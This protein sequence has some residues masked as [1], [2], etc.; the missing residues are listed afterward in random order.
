MASSPPAEAP[1]PTIVNVMWGLICKIPNEYMRGSL[2]TERGLVPPGRVAFAGPAL[3]LFSL[4]SSLDST[5]AATGY[6]D[7]EFGPMMIIEA[8][9]LAALSVEPE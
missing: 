8:L 4:L 9:L 6:G 1:M 5:H 2:G 7:A 3:S